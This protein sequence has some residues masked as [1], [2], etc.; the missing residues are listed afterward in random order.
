MQ[1][2]ICDVSR[3]L[4]RLVAS[5]P[6]PL[7]EDPHAQITSPSIVDRL[8]RIVDVFVG[9]PDR[10]RYQD[11]SKELWAVELWIYERCDPDMPL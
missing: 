3:A 10:H 5:L 2:T 1:Y 6:P 11:F 8:Q 7:F 9:L 4:K